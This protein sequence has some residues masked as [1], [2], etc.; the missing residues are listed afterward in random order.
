MLNDY[1]SL[2]KVGDN[3]RKERKSQGLT[4]LEMHLRSGVDSK[5]LGKIE[6]GNNFTVCTLLRIACALDVEPDTLL[7]P[8]EDT[9]VRHPKE[10][11]SSAGSGQD[12]EILARALGYIC[13]SMPPY[14]W[15]R[16]VELMKPRSHEKISLKNAENGADEKD[17]ET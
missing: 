6:K 2:R 17:E 5:N 8:R 3:I 12:C 9:D 1:E 7:K 4:L 10:N 13:R 14:V 11:G 16:L 15:E